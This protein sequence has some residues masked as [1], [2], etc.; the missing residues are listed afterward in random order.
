MTV[1]ILE[2]THMFEAFEID[3]STLDEPHNM[4]CQLQ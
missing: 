2:I 3:Y 1:V 4:T